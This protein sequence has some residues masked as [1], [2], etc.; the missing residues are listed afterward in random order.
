MTR[1]LLLPAVLLVLLQVPA[2]AQTADPPAPPK[3][4]KPCLFYAGDFGPKSKNVNGLANEED[5]LVSY[6]AVLVP[7][8]VPKTQK[9]KVTGLF[10]NDFSSVDLIDPQQAAWSISTGVTQGSCGTAVAS[11][12][13]HASFTPTGRGDFGFNEYTTLV[14]IKATQ[15]QPGRY[16]LTTIPECTNTSYCSDARYFATSFAGKPADP[17]GPPEPCNLAYSTTTPGRNCT[18]GQHQKMCQRFSAGVLG[19]EQGGDAL[20]DSDGK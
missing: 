13:S 19:T 15:L 18:G 8:D 20:R 2:L 17:F 16:W 10:T 11:G 6:A 12:N 4:C 1:K 3:Y 7:F 5:I 9:W 14:K